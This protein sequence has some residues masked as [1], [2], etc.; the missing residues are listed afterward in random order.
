MLTIERVTND[1]TYQK[2]LPVT[3]MTTLIGI[4]ASAVRAQALKLPIAKLSLGPDN[5]TPSKTLTEFFQL[6]FQLPFG[7]AAVL[8]H[9]QFFVHLLKTAVVR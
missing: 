2:H 7:V 9:S 8:K 6:S 3:S 5:F 4:H 1:D